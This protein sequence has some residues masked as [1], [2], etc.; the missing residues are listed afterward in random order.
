MVCT[1]SF[2]FKRKG[3]GPLGMGLLVLVQAGTLR[4]NQIKVDSASANL[5]HVVFFVFFC[6]I[7]AG[8]LRPCG[9]HHQGCEQDTKL[10]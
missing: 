10:T 7:K 9:H 6:L 4:A 8:T 3:L 2:V 5:F 1:S